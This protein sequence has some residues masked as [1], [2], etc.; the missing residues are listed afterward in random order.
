MGRVSITAHS[1][2]KAVGSRQDPVLINDGPT[3]DVETYKVHTGLPWPLSLKGIHA[4]Q[5]LPLHMTL[6]T[7]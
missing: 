3:A 6:A 2:V 1:P 7:G 5:Y 4:S